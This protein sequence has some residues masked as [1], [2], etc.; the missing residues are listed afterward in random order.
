M[1]VTS[2]VTYY[3]SELTAPILSELTK[4]QH[5]AFAPLGQGPRAH[6]AQSGSLF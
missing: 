1:K 3:S 5:Q 4:L 2:Y 6:M